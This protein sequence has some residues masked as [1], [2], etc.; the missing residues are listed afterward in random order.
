LS[1]ERF[2]RRSSTVDS[3]EDVKERTRNVI[4]ALGPT[5]LDV[6]VEVGTAILNIKQIVELGPGDIIRLPTRTN[7]LFKV[8]VGDD[9]NPRFLARAG[10]IGRF[11][12]IEIIDFFEE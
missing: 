8:F 3:D 4:Q 6:R 10:K 12:G 5:P 9:L 2:F 7:D 1:T 11:M